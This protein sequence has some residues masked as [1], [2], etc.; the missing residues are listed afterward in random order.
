M[1]WTDRKSIEVIKY[2]QDRFKVKTYLETGTFKGVGARLHSHNFEEV[3]TCEINSEYVKISK[4]NL[5][6]CPNVHVFNME[7]RD[8]LSDFKIE[9]YE[10]SRKDVVFIYLDAHFYDPNLPENERFVVL[11]EL[12]ALADFKKCIICIHDFDNNLGHITY[13]GIHL[14]LDLIK[15]DL[16]N[17]NPDFKL[18]TNELKSCDIIS[19]DDINFIEGLEPDFDT[20]DNLKYALSTPRLTYRGILYALPNDL[21][22]KELEELGL[23]EIRYF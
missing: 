20:L 14:N 15:E 6:C 4:E 17:I 21:S 2:L 13:D 18:Y 19:E 9:Y 1:S 16:M 22:D 8:F 5:S 23:K 10:K 7:S 12:K 3:L 11:K